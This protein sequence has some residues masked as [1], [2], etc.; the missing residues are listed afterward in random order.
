MYVIYIFDRCS[1]CGWMYSMWVVDV[2][3]ICNKY[4][5]CIVYRK[6]WCIL[7]WIIDRCIEEMDVF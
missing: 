2:L 5:L 3:F 1:K 7:I 4:V 6:D